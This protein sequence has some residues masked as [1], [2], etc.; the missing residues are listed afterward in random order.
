MNKLTPDQ[1]AMLAAWQQHTYAEFVLKDADA[2]LATMT[3]NPYVFLVPSGIARVGRAAVREFY[4]NHFLPKIPPDLEI[5]SLSQTFG[6][7]RIVEEMVMRFTHTIDMDWILPGVRP[8][9][10]RAEFVLAGIIQL[11]D[12]KVAHEHLYWDQATLL[13]QMGVL[14]HPLA[15]AGVGSAEQLLKLRVT[16]IIVLQNRNRIPVRWGAAPFR[17]REGRRCRYYRIRSCS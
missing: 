3:E 12:S 1:Q 13:S 14:D 16:R 10:R 7:D 17:K 2:A 15:A 11:Q 8:T 9:G 4:A 6:Y 5:T